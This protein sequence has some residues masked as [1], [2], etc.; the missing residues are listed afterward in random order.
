MGK[1]N[2]VSC[3]EPR[4]SFVLWMQTARTEYPT[5]RRVVVIAHI[6]LDSVMQLAGTFQ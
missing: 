2:G 5:M 6:N 4:L 1:E 3:R